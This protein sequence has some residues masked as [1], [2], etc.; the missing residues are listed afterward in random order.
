MFYRDTDLFCSQFLQDGIQNGIAFFKLGN[1]GHDLVVSSIAACM[2]QLVGQF[3]QFSGVGC[4]VT[5]HVLHQR[6]QLVHGS[7]GMLMVM[8]VMMLVTMVVQMLMLM[9]MCM[10]MAVGVMMF[11]GMGMTV[12]G[13]FMG[14]RMVM[15]MMMTAMGLIHMAMMVL[16]AAFVTVVVTTAMVF[17]FV[18]NSYSPF[19]L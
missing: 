4:V 13:V 14:M 9:G 7:M 5:G 6:Q 16:T 11:V 18:H 2:G 12:M 8:M 10:F 15:L 1:S 17:M 3:S 19:I